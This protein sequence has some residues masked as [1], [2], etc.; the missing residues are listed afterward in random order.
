MPQHQNIFIVAF[1]DTNNLELAI[2][3]SIDNLRS[4]EGK[5]QT[6]SFLPKH[7]VTI[8][9]GLAVRSD[10]MRDKKGVVII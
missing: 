5:S 9:L 3:V 1:T 2:P 4:H 8:S 7:P 10:T 6:F